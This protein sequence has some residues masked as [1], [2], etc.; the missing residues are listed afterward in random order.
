[1]YLCPDRRAPQRDDVLL[2]KKKDIIRHDM[3]FL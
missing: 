3:K 2:I 1:V